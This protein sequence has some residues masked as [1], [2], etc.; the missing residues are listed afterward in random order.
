MEDREDLD[1]LATLTEIDAEGEAA[2]EHG[3]PCVLVETRKVL[4]VIEDSAKELEDGVQEGIP[5]ARLAVFVPLR[6]FF[7]VGFDER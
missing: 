6:R 5:Q 4:G 3:A 2:R 1:A 7:E